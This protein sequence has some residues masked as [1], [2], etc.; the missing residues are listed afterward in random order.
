MPA[1][2]M[3]V[4][5][6]GRAKLVT[7]V[8]GTKNSKNLALGFLEPAS[9]LLVLTLGFIQDHFFK[10]AEMLFKDQICA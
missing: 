6:G 3:A 4:L 2:H 1:P 10:I 9:A 8:P 7:T 5:P